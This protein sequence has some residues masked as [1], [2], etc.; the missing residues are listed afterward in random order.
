MG[1][2]IKKESESLINTG[3]EIPRDYNIEKEDS[4]WLDECKY[5]L[6]D[7]GYDSSK[8]INRLEDKEIHSIIDIRNCWKD[9]EETHQYKDTGLVYDYKGTVWYVEDNGEKAELIYKGYDKSTDSLRY[10]FKPQ[11]L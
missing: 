3:L 10:G 2:F 6:A 11:N 4:K 8:I 7:K 1:D 9:G 5:F